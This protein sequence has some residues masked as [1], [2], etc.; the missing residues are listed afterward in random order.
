MAKKRTKTSKAAAGKRALRA[1]P[2]P[3]MA[4]YRQR[5]AALDGIVLADSPGVSW[6]T[7]NDT[8]RSAI[9]IDAGGYADTVVT[10]LRAGNVKAAD[11][12]EHVRQHV[13]TAFEL[14]FRMALARYR[15]HLEHVPELQRRR[16]T[17]ASRS[18]KGNDARREKHNLDARDASIAAEFA[19]LRATMTAGE[20]QYALAQKH[21]LSDKQIR[22]V[23]TK[24]RKGK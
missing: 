3:G 7:F 15:E 6:Q 13:C 4:E 10:L 14:G 1:A 16:A 5:L 17:D 11:I 21:G 23:L 20:A 8:L 12:P 18:R 9:D 24:A 22:N 19:T 2:R